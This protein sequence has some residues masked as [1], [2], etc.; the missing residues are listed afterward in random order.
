M[1]T[2]ELEVA[3]MV[4]EVFAEDKYCRP[5]AST[6]QPCGLARPKLCAAGGR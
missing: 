5:P 3:E 4:K 1:H 6:P 2:I